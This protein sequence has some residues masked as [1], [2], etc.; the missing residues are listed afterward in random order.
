M[1]KT[2]LISGATTGIGYDLAHLF[3]KDKNNLLL[4]ARNEDKLNEVARELITKYSITVNVLKADLS[5]LNSPK[6]IYGFAKSKGLFIETLVNNAGFGSNGKFHEL[7]L[8]E[9]INMI[10]VNITSLVYLCRLFLPEMIQNNEGKILNVASTA[11]FQPGPFMSNYYATKAYV[12]H[13]TEGLAVELKNTKIKVS[14]LCPGATITEFQNRANIDNTLLF[15]GPFVMDSPT[16][17]KIGYEGL[18]KGKTI[19]I[20]GIMNKLLALSVG[21]SPRILIRTIAGRLNSSR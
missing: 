11:G 14:A 5:D 19:V 3:G 12:L 8:E 4:I 13:F 20:P 15:K 17:A 10:R 6:K 1:M 9:E 16:V 18:L 7:P 2:V 21:F